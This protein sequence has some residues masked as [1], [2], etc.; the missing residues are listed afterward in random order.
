LFDE[1]QE[2]PLFPL[3]VVLF[4]GMSLPLHIFEDRYRLMIHECLEAEREF[5]VLM[6]RAVPSE[7]GGTTEHVVG[8][9]ARITHVQHL[10]DGRMHILTSGVE[11][12]RVLQL[13]RMEPYV[14]GRIEFF[15]LEDT[16]SPQVRDLA[17]KVGKRF[18]RYLRLVGDILGATIE[19][20]S[21]PRDPSGLGYLIAMAMEIPLEEKQALLSIRTLP[22]LLAEECFLLQRE[23][24]VLDRMRQVQ[25]SNTGYFR[26]ITQY[27]SLN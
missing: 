13:M 5:G 22:A 7:A 25:E 15:P 2:L 19:L 14:V 16:D 6:A 17:S 8:T 4:P 12:F 27:V 23:E 18:V 21:S 9:S 24:M 11:R 20:G 3:N 10:E 26:G 1:T